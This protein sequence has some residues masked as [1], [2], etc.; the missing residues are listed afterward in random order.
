[1]E[2]LKRSL[3]CRRCESLVGEGPA[4]RPHESL[5]FEARVRC[6]EGSGFVAY[7][8]CTS[9]GALLRY[10]PFSAVGFFG[11]TTATPTNLP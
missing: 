6:R 3:I 2:A 9:C 8:H 4:T 11:W 5:T 10:N 7:Y 1:M